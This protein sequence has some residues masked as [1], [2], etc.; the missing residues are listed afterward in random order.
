M[1][2][3]RSVAPGDPK[4]TLVVGFGPKGLTRGCQTI[5]PAQFAD[6]ALARSG[7]GSC[8]VS[9]RA[10]PNGSN[11]L[12]TFRFGVDIYVGSDRFEEPKLDAVYPGA[13]PRNR[14]GLESREAD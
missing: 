9:I 5:R 13:V 14:T 4:G 11:S 2:C 6:Q 7:V 8:F 3:H 1:E 12:K 10:L